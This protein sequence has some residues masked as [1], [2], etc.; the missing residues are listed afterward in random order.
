MAN[1]PASTTTA[2]PRRQKEIHEVRFVAYPKLLFT[3]PLLLAGFFFWPLAGMGVDPEW[4]GWAYLWITMIVVMTLGVDVD[5]NQAAFWVILVFGIWILG[6]WLRDVPGITVFGDI[7]K[8]FG[9][10]D[11]KY[12]RSLGLALS[13]I[14]AV[15]FAVMLG[16]AR[17]NDYWRITHN[18][19]EHYSFGRADDTLGRGA[20]QIRTTFPDVLELLLGGAGTLIVYS[21]NGNQELRRIP[22][23]M[24]LPMVR[25]RLNKILE[26][27]AITESNA[28]EEE[29]GQV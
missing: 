21:A 20:K 17:L 7:Y 8:W 27:I 14:L 11:L 22:H 10:L 29:E 1:S 28:A 6:L 16:W 24:F 5:R 9:G 13:L 12:D 23:V 26:R 19:F 3:W 15:P 25:A 2:T 4:L 18:E